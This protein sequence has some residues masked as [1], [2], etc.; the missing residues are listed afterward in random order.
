MADQPCRLCADDI[1]QHELEIGQVVRIPVAVARRAIAKPEATP[2]GRDDSPVAV[3][4]IDDELERCR[5]I[6]PAVQHDQRVRRAGPGVAPL[7]QVIAQPSH[8]DESGT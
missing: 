2:V 8:I 5:H 7:A 3:E 6:H 4:R 1:V